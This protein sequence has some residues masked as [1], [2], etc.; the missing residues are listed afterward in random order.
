MQV[1]AP[2]AAKADRYRWVVLTN[3]TAAVF[4]S[5]LDGSIVIISLP[6][7]FRGIHLDPL[8]PSNIGYLLW[9]IMG[10][11]LVQSVL[12]VSLG[13]LGDMFGRVKIYNF[14]FTVFT[15]ASILLSFDPFAGGRAAL[16]L[17]GW[18]VL[19][20][21]GGSMLTANSAAILTDAFPAERRGFALG[22]NQV[23]ALAGQFIGLVAGGL[24]AA[25]D[26]RAVFWVNVPV[27]IFGTIWAYRKLREPAGGRHPGRIDWWG[28]LTFAIG[29]SA[30]LVAI[31]MGLQP[32]GGHPTGWQNPVVL[33]ILAAGV[34]LLVAFVVV[35]SR[36]VEPMVALA[37]FRNR[38]FAAGNAATLASSLAQGGL[39][40]ILIIWLQGIWLPLHGY[41]YDQTPLWAGIFLLPLT[42]GFLL[43]GP[44]AGT[45]SDRFGTRGIATSGM[46]LFGATFVG[47]LLLPIDFPYWAFALLIA[48][49]GIGSGMF[50]APNT[51]AIMSSVPSAQ[52]GVASGMRA[53]FQNSGTA[54]SI[55]VFFSL[56]VAGLSARLPAA[57]SSGLIQQGVPAGVAH[58]VGALPP[59]ATL[60]S[61]VLGVNPLEHLLAPSGM[62]AALPAANQQ[63]LTGREFFP[64]LIAAPFEHGLAVV[65]VASAIL[66]VL[67][68]VASSLRGSTR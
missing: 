4:M 22:F 41:D 61:A 32:H 19:Q 54:L 15:I 48:V 68:A 16:W 34:L 28:N 8:A 26:W 21:A 17:I 6:A 23:A 7:I 14:G 9:M 62:L 43:S 3:T 13:R 47:L 66:A 30:I 25:W 12:V 58:D 65:F 64:H 24:L 53:T 20:A 50:S 46:L 29:L 42:V 36:V 55:G 40:F 35:E 45:M 1:S 63:T 38:A 52:R 57:M 10:Y 27:G 49:N 2:P 18:R 37:L 59:V 51:S 33:I 60:F 5:A 31:T 67:A 56:M 39:Q 44:L 11:R